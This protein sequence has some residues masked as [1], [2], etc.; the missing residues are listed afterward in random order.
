MKKILLGLLF[1]L[2]LGYAL[3]ASRFSGTY[4]D[5]RKK[6]SLILYATGGGKDSNGEVSWRPSGLSSLVLKYPD[7]TNTRCFLHEGK[8]LTIDVDSYGNVVPVLVGYKM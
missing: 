8:L 7:G 2:I 1:V 3:V 5:S 4:V 6:P